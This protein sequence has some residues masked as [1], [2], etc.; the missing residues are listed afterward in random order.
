M[1]ARPLASALRFTGK[2]EFRAVDN[3][4][5]LYHRVDLLRIVDI[6][7]RVGAEQ[8]QI[9]RSASAAEAV[10]WQPRTTIARRRPNRDSKMEFPHSMTSDFAFK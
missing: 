5:C 7:Q 8:Y 1:G 4:R 10:P 9:R 3:L 6:S 2:N